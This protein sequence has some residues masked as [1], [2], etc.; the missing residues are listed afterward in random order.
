M[1][2]LIA[3]FAAVGIELSPE[4]VAS[5]DAALALVERVRP[6]CEIDID[7]FSPNSCR[8]SIWVADEEY[9]GLSAE[10]YPSVPIALL[11]ALLKS[12]IETDNAE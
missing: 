12:L 3:G 7:I 11:T 6:G 4:Q 10:T 9:F 5:I 2:E 8:A 1:D